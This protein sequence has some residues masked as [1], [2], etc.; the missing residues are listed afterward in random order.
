MISAFLFCVSGTVGFGHQM[1]SMST[2][3]IHSFK[4]VLKMLVF[5]NDFNLEVHYLG[6]LVSLFLG[7]LFL[8]FLVLL[9]CTTQFC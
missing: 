3:S 6:F 2:L 4:L 5:G 1:A 9:V 8:L 7:Q